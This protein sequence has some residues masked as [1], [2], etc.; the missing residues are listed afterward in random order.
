MSFRK[1]HPLIK[2]VNSTLVDLP[3]PA[4]LSVN[5][6]YG[7]LLG[8]VLVIQL[9]TGIVL[10]TRFSGHSDMSFDSV[11]SIYQDS[12]YG[13][14]LRLVHST[15]A[16]FF[17]LFI[18]LHIGRGLYYGSYVYPEVWNIGVLIYLI[19]MGTAFLG[20]VLPWGQMSYWAATVIT[21]LLSAIPWLG[22]T[23][24]E[25]VWGGFA[26]GNPTLTRFFALHYLLPFVVTALVILHIFYL[27]IYGSSN[28]LGIS[29]NTN[30]VS[31]HYYYSVKDLYVYFVFFFVFMV[32]TLKYGYVFMDAE[33]F[34]PANPL[35]T[36]THI[37]PEWYFLFAYAILR[38]IP[39]KLGGV[40]G[41]LLAVLVL[42]LFSVSTSKLLFSGTIY[43]P[44]ARLLYWSLVSNFF[45]LTWLGSCPAESPY[46]EVALVAT[47]TYFTFMLTM[48]ALPH[49]STYLYLKS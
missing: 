22:P 3:S 48:C 36:P 35:V 2:I 14:L 30:K 29:S 45:L 1:T 6:N 18:Y 16:S 25:W 13:W 46:N 43:S 8:L 5:W 32:F 42:F 33:N 26:V 7:S 34:I 41:L 24:V 37:Q 27:H 15:G 4:N 47:V 40:V 44:L 12:N 38:S 11:I 10:A 39:N 49:I 28:P 19:L 17:F 23:M 20:Y 31:F 9:I 21:N